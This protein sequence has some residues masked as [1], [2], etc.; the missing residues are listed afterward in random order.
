WRGAGR[1]RGVAAALPG[2]RPRA[3]R[4]VRL[5]GPAPGRLRS[6]RRGPGPGRAF[7]P[8]QAVLSGGSPDE[9]LP[10]AVWSSRGRVRGMRGRGRALDRAAVLPRDDRL[11]DR[12]GGRGAARRAR[13]VGRVPFL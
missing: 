9:L 12:A 8:Q 2:R 11:T 5:R 3:P 4:V 10:R 1:N 6:R 7:D 13:A